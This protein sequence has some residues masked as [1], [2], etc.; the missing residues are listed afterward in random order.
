MTAP[1]SSDDA[2]RYETKF[3]TCSPVIIKP[4]DTGT[5]YE[6]VQ[7]ISAPLTGKTRGLL[8]IITRLLLIGTDT[9]KPAQWRAILKAQMLE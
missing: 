4:K 5:A 2:D 6:L 1:S 7:I 8:L 9:R 3:R